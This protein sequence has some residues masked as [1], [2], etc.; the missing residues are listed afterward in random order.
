MIFGRK[1][2]LDRIPIEKIL[3][4][5]WLWVKALRRVTSAHEDKVLKLRDLAC[6]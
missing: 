3:S 5:S 4:G 1:M 6:T 2:K